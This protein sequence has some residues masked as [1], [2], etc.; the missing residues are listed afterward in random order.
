MN[1]KKSLEQ[2]FQFKKGMPQVLRRIEKDGKK[3]SKGTK[4]VKTIWHAEF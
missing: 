4:V 3:E 1:E 2:N